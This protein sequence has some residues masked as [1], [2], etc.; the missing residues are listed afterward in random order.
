MSSKLALFTTKFISKFLDYRIQNYVNVNNQIW[1]NASFDCLQKLIV[2]DF[3]YKN[4]VF[5]FSQDLA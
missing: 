4:C 3:F 5:T 2:I 1:T